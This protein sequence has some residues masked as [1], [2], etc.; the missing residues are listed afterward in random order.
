MFINNILG[1]FHHRQFFK[2]GSSDP[3]ECFFVHQ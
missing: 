3:N 2:V 1:Y